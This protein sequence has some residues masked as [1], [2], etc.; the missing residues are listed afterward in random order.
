M[1]LVCGDA[2]E[3]LRELETGSVDMIITSPPYWGLRDYG[4][5]KWE[6][7][8]PACDH[9]QEKPLS[10]DPRSTLGYPADG[11]PRRIGKSNLTK[12]S[13]KIYRERCEKCGARR[14]DSQLGLERT[15]GEYI[16]R[17]VEVFREARRVLKRTGTFWLNMGDTYSSSAGFDRTKSTTLSKSLCLIPERLAI[18]LEDDG[19]R[20]RNKI[21]WA[22]KNGMPSSAKDRL[23]PRWEYLFFLT[24]AER[25][26]FGLDSI[27]EPHTA[28]GSPPGN[29]SR[30]Y[31]DR[32]PQHHH[33]QKRRPGQTQSFHP[34]GK[35]PGDVWWIATQPNPI[36]G[37]HFAA[38]PEALCERPI[39]AGCPP[40]GLVLDPFCGTGTAGV[41]ARRLGRD[42]IGIDLSPDYI[43]V[44]EKRILGSPAQL[45]LQA[46]E[47]RPV[48][49]T[50]P[51]SPRSS[52]SRAMILGQDPGKSHFPGKSPITDQ[53]PGARRPRLDETKRKEAPCR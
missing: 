31:F 30:E 17:L 36:R 50:R 41:V 27:R 4:T 24:Q 29:K 14:I 49:R 40:G 48:S 13:K 28:L 21:I 51:R 44:A 43:R 34:G 47:V 18:A 11:G 19:W 7:G 23:T 12:V 35:N 8:D 42:F 1:K 25:Y 20:I 52:D 37:A 9:K 3:A 39:K 6:G 15:P 32:D 10:E 16:A 22:K 26:Y 5:G 2:L 45:G 38:F 46:M 53:D 33:R